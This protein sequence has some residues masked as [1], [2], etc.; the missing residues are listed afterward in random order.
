MH[1]GTSLIQMPVS[2][3][4]TLISEVSLH[5]NTVLCT[6]IVKCA[7]GVQIRG[8]PQYIKI[9]HLINT[10]LSLYMHMTKITR[11][12]RQIL[13]PEVGRG[14]IILSV[15]SL[16][17]EEYA[18]E[19]LFNHMHCACNLHTD[20]LYLVSKYCIPSRT[21]L[22]EAARYLESSPQTSASTYTLDK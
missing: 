22:H 7:Q 14:V 11:I 19:T 10:T 17:T 2:A 18:T 6:D 13:Q 15:K 12:M 1:S 8:A 16:S 4:G 20:R 9:M 3:G 21:N 5:A